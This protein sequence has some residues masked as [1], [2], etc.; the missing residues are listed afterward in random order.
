MRT[1]KRR[2]IVRVRLTQVTNTGRYKTCPY[3]C[4]V[5]DV[6]SLSLK[7]INVRHCR[8]LSIDVE[9]THE[10]DRNREEQNYN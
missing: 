1:Q 3:Q 2:E 9:M 8:D 6:V 10:S 4:L 7:H 5:V